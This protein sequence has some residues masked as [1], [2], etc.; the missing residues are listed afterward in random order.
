MEP[1]GQRRANVWMAPGARPQGKK[2]EG[3]E[4]GKPRGSRTPRSGPGGDR[5]RPKPGGSKRR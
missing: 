4:S 3:E 1:P 2:A 5:P